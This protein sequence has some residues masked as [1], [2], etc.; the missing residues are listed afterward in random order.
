MP[1]KTKV[2]QLLEKEWTTKDVQEGDPEKFKNLTT[3]GNWNDEAKIQGLKNLKNVLKDE[4]Y[5]E[6][7]ITKA[8][9]PLLKEPLSNDEKNILWGRLIKYIDEIRNCLNV[10]EGI[11]Y[12]QQQIYYARDYPDLNS[13]SDLDNLHFLIMEQ[14]IQK[15]YRE[16]LSKLKSKSVDKYKEMEK[17]IRDSFNRMQKHELNLN[18]RRRDRKEETK[19]AGSFDELAIKIA[20][21]L[22]S[23]KNEMDDAVKEWKSEDKTDI[24]G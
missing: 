9:T 11:F 7:L 2:E 5:I 13:S 3:Y 4:D 18:L 10:K 19:T 24:P 17:L 20:E 8:K 23:K 14:I 22:K 21:R 12:V 1:E 16:K 6:Y 15:R